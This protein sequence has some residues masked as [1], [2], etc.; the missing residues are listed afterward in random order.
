MSCAAVNPRYG[1]HLG[2]HRDYLAMCRRAA[3]AFAEGRRVH[4]GYGE[5]PMDEHEFWR[6]FRRAL[7]RRITGQLPAWRRL[8]P[9]YQVA[10]QRD[11]NRIRDRVQHRVRI[12][13]FET[14]ELRRRFGH[15]LSS[16]D[17]A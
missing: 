3:R 14:P 7:H 8:D 1:A 12:F 2:Y 9:A 16:Y 17:E 15:L 5:P 10:L 13:Q 11:A 6:A 4:F